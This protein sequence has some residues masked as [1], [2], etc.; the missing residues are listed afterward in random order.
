VT[1]FPDASE[2]SNLMS[3]IFVVLKEF[4]LTLHIRRP[5]GAVARS[6]RWLF[7]IL[8]QHEFACR[9]V[10]IANS[11]C[12]CCLGGVWTALLLPNN[13]SVIVSPDLRLTSEWIS[14][15]LKYDFGR[16]FKIIHTKW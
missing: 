16:I 15:Y 12:R 5:T 7:L 13:P 3:D 11:S 9:L 2:P 6:H 4:T 10:T 1:I 14:W 8:E